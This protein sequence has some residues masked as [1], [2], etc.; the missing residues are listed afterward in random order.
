MFAVDFNS[1]TGSSCSE[2]QSFNNKSLMADYHTTYKRGEGESTQWEDIQRRLGNFAPAE[3]VHK[4]DPFKPAAEETKDKT[5]IDSKN[6]DE[7]EDL[8]DETGDDSFLERYRQQRLQELNSSSGSPNFGSLR[9]IQRDQWLA[10]V[11]NAGN[12]VWVVVYLFK[13]DVSDCKCMTQCLQE[14]ARKH[15]HTKFIQI[16][17]TEAIA[18]YPDRSL[19]TLL[20]YRDTRCVQSLAGLAM[21]GGK[22]A[23][24]ES[25]AYALNRFG[26]VCRRPGEANDQEALTTEIKALLEKLAM[27][28]NERSQGP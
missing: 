2:S 28:Q 10:E 9:E 18:G 16:I 1:K 17:S 26:P 13:D 27:S 7:L 25:V 14:L 21:F 22:R 15:R 5:W 3:P 11:T 6:L 20:L 23:S 19:P 8:E 24:P 4:P 12:D